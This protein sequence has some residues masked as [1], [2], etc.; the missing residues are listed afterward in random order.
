MWVYTSTPPYVFMADFT[1]T[2]GCV[3]LSG[4]IIII[5]FYYYLLK[6]QMGC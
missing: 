2:L 4:V 3:L 1:F 5:F 6:L